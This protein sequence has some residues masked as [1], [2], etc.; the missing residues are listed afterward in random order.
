MDF[1]QW[2]HSIPVEPH[3]VQDAGVF[4]V[5]PVRRHKN[6]DIAR[7]ALEGVVQDWRNAFG[8]VRDRDQPLTDSKDG[9]VNGFV[10][11]EALPERLAVATRLNDLG[12]LHDGELCIIKAVVAWRS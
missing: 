7:K 6:A 12:F 5:L 3:L 1:G 2:R 4:T 9:E 11:P 10:V 8:D